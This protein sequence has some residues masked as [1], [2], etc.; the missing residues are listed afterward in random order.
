MTVWPSARVEM[1]YFKQ[2][3][4]TRPW[5]VAA[6][7]DLPT[8][9]ETWQKA[10]TQSSIGVRRLLHPRCVPCEPQKSHSIISQ[11]LQYVVWCNWLIIN[12]SKDA[13][14]TTHKRRDNSEREIDRCN[15]KSWH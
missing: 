12:T 13:Q 9:L 10:Q 2:D 1:L 11:E 3:E 15:K 5:E 8:E 7:D 14:Q 6:R 4:S